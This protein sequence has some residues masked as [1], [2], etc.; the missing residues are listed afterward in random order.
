VPV[1]IVLNLVLNVGP[2]RPGSA[3]HSA[4]ESGAKRVYRLSGGAGRAGA[5]DCGLERLSARLLELC[6]LDK[7]QL[8]VG[9][10]ATPMHAGLS[11]RGRRTRCSSVCTCGG[12]GSDAARSAGYECGC[13]RLVR[14]CT[15]DRRLEAPS[16]KVNSP[17]LR[18]CTHRGLIRGWFT[19]LVGCAR[20]GMAWI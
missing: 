2:S 1:S 15:P 11:R 6:H 4:G 9:W 19:R 8:E 16:R 17:A 10:P 13:A 20:G 12:A 5:V 7:R 18:R 3:P 14:T